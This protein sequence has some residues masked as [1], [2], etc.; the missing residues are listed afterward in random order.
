MLAVATPPLPEE[1][2]SEDP[3]EQEEPLAGYAG[4]VPAT[5]GGPVNPGEVDGPV[6]LTQVRL[7]L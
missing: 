4:A 5:G 2:L 3:L 6:K 7:L 1:K